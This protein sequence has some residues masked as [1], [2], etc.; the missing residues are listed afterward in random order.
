MPTCDDC[1]FEAASQR[2]LSQH[3]TMSHESGSPKQTYECAACGTT[4]DDYPSRRETRG[5]ENFFCSNECKHNFEEGEKFYFECAQCGDEVER[6]PS[7][8]DEMGDYEIRNHFC[9][10]ACES[11]F[12]Q[13][14]WVG[15][16]HPNWTENTVA[17]TCDECGADIELMEYYD[18]RLSNHFCDKKCH[19]EFQIEQ[20]VAECGW[21]DDSFELRPSQRNSQT[22]QHFC[23][24]ACRSAWRS[25]A[26]CGDSN[27][28]WRGGKEPYYGPNW[29][30][31]RTAAL[32]RDDYTCQHCGLT[33][34]EHIDTYGYDLHVHHIEPLKSFGN[35][36][37]AANDLDNLVTL[38]HK[39]HG[40]A[41]FGG[42]MYATG[43][44]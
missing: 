34:A 31:S 11:Q 40:Q 43:G 44:D 16:D 37:E 25:D 39:C 36:Y 19:D 22:D 29:L 5:R 3:Q 4:F 33:R 23:S 42:G 13:D 26:Q 15:E 12:K 7:A 35:N 2:G 20:K 30:A 17:K 38:C 6:Q 18:N 14:N 9:D 32:D 8:V 1:G 27:T 28:M 41:E 24:D 10:K 21:C